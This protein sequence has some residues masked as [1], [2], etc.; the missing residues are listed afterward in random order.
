MF[1]REELKELI[2]REQIENLDDF[3]ELMRKI[4]KEVL[5]AIY[6]GEITAHL[7]YRKHE[8]NASTDGNARN[9]YTQKTV[10]AQLGPIELDVP[11]DRHSTYEPKIV[12]K[13]QRDISGIETKVIS[14]YAK[15]MTTRDIQQHIYDIYGY[16][17]SP[18]T[19][20][21]ITDR[22]MEHVREWQARPLQ[23]V[24]AVVFM[25]AMMVKM[26]YDGVIKNVAIYSILGIDLDGMKSCLGLYVAE[27]ESAKYW[28]TV[29]NELKNRGVQDILIFAVD[30]LA[31]ISEAIA[32]AFPNAEV[33]KCIVHQIRNSLK[34]VP[35]KERKPV[36]ADLRRIYTASSEAE[37]FA[38]LE[39]FAEKWDRK[40]PHISRSWLANWTELSTFYKYSPE[41]RTLIYTTNPIESY[42]RAVRKVMKSRGVFPSEEA[43]LKLM[44]LATQ[45]TERRWTKVIPNWGTIYSQ[46]TV[47]F[48]D[49]V[50]KYS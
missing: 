31:G 42:H 45:D 11:R 22:V 24:Y 32:A 17:I 23:P 5:E 21:T 29:M 50:T 36:A 35:W 1:D 46:L 38:E 41:I 34:Y 26:R 19:I 37:G 4:T 47:Y 39:R 6:D 40:Y 48:G 2:K 43:V 16:E 18:E 30:N 3:Q 7:G 25:D 13:R 44:Y 9:G 20:S 28:L 14:M 12:K 49:R 33:Q 27:T 10:Q 8:Q 15:G